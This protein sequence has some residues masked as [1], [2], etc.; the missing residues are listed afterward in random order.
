MVLMKNYN[1]AGF[2]F[3]TNYASRKGQE[4]EANPH[5]AMLFYWPVVHRQVRT[6]TASCPRMLSSK[7]R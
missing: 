7:T 6:L 4:L 1:D 3:F 2:S 5:A